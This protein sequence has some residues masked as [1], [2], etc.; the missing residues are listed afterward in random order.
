MQWRDAMDKPSMLGLQ[1]SG[2]G[3]ATRIRRAPLYPFLAAV[4]PA[5]ALAAANGGDIVRPGDLARPLAISLVAAAT[6]WLVSRAITRDPDARALPAFIATAVFVAHGNAVNA[7]ARWVPVAATSLPLALLPATVAVILA[8]RSHV[9]LR[10]LTRHLNLVLAIMV[11]WASADL[12]WRWHVQSPKIILSDPA[13]QPGADPVPPAGEKPHL[14]L[15][16][17]DKYTGHQSLAA[18]FDYDNTPFEASLQR[19]GFFVPKAAKANYVQTFLAVASML[20]WQYL[21]EVAEQVGKDNPRASVAFPL[22]EDNRTWRALRA[23]GYEFVFLP[24]WFPATRENRYADLQLPDP[25]S[26]THEFEA[27]WIRGTVLYPLL[28][29]ICPVVHCPA[30]VVPYLPESPE[31]IDWKFHQIPSF[32]ESKRPVFVLAHLIVPHEPYIYN[33]DCSHRRPY[34]PR[35]EA[36]SNE[37]AVKVAYVA[38]IRCLNT[39]IDTMVRQILTRTTR[40]AII[41]LQSDHGHGRLGAG[42]RVPPE[43]Y[44][45]PAQ[46]RERTDVFAAY[47]LPGAPRGLVYDSISPVNAMRAVMR[48]YYRLDRPPLPDAS[49]WSPTARPYD[50][51]RVR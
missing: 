37:A 51:V 22:I 10:A 15:I 20:N 29:R 36:G 19:Q 45:N 18:N 2:V 34:W 26:L 27:A 44:L 42:G 21:D 28:E 12:L 1:S 5:L 30:A 9:S 49:F 13:G 48:Y 39:K 47:L 32:A 23:L 31:S 50:F 24:T 35:S 4:Y 16:F 25:S 8:R 46:V 38:Q 41:L 7:M 17:L 40:P 3:W 14:F 6:A 43:A 11:G 33:A